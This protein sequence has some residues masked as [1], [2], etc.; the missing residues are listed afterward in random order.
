M[1]QIIINVSKIINIIFRFLEVF[2]KYITETPIYIKQI[3]ACIILHV[4]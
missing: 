4:V 3:K 1:P 2:I